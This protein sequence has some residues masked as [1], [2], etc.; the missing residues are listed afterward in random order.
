MQEITNDIL[1][2]LTQVKLALNDITSK[3]SDSRHFSY[4]YINLFSEKLDTL[5]KSSSGVF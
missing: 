2:I 5:Q 3:K 1:S 4:E